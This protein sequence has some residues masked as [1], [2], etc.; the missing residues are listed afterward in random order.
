MLYPRDRALASP[1]EP[2]PG[3]HPPWSLNSMHNVAVEQVEETTLLGVLLDCKLSRAKHIDC[4]VVKMGRGLSVRHHMQ[5]NSCPV[6]CGKTNTAAQNRAGRLALKCTWRANVNNM[7]I[8]HSWLRVDE[9]LTIT[10]DR[11]KK[12]WCVESTKLHT[13]TV[14][15]RCFKCSF[16]FVFLSIGVLHV[17]MFYVVWLLLFQ[18]LNG[19][20]N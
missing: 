11:C 19:D 16:T 12:Y 2:E 20:L 13:N 17:V 15:F 6:R 10:V 3:A 9:G 18:Q 14:F 4:I 5:P 7:H 8:S 1:W